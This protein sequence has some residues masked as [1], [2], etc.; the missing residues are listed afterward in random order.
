MVD[1]IS[2]KISILL[3][4]LAISLIALQALGFRMGLD[5]EGGTR[6]V[7]SIDLDRALKEGS[8]TTVQY[9]NPDLLKR[10][11]IEIWTKRIDPQG[12]KGA[13]VRTE[14]SNRIVIE[15]PGSATAADKKVS[16]GLASPMATDDVALYLDL[17][18]ELDLNSVTSQPEK[19]KIQTKRDKFLS[20]YPATGGLISINGERMRYSKR[21]GNMLR[22]LTRGVEKSDIKTHAAG[23]IVELKASDPWRQKIENTGNMEFMIGATDQ[24]LSDPTNRALSTDLNSERAAME[25]W[26]LE[27]PGVEIREYNTLL[28]ERLGPVSRLRWFANVTDNPDDQLKDLL[29]PLIIEADPKWRFDGTDFPTF[30]PSQ[31]NLGLPAVGFTPTPEQQ[32]AFGDF[33][34]EHENQPMAIVINGEIVTFPN[35]NGRLGNGGVIE[36]GRGGFTSDEVNDLV[37]VLRSGSLVIRPDFEAQETVGASLGSNYVKR[38]FT[39]AALGLVMVLIFMLVYYRR[40]GVLAGISLIFNLILLLGA[41][42]FIRATLTLPGVA[43]IILTVGMAVDANILIYERIR[44]E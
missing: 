15:L 41:M 14:G 21:V 19:N 17:G 40:L 34:E 5:L 32:S 1:H 39:S 10:E 16:T 11:L 35:I 43:G 20:D 6:L 42:A 25:A 23:D 3:T 38:G 33:T 12:V 30:F 27:N 2:R 18:P 44:E 36:G 24:D 9:E 8:I 31:D 4:L 37:S 13:R 22:Q 26:L 29:A 28:S 7:Y